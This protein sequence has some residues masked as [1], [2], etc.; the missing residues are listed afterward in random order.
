MDRHTLIIN[1]RHEMPRNK[2]LFW[3]GITILLWIG[4]ISLWYPVFE[5]FYRMATTEVPAA[6]IAKWIN[7]NI[8]RVTFIHGLEMLVVTPVVLFILSWLKRHQ[9]PS[10]H[11][12][13]TNVDYAAHFKIAV[14]QLEACGNS[15]LVTVFHDAQGQITAVNNQID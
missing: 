4:F 15:Q 7:G 8:H 10:E 5:I 6:E 13:Y 2:V 1:K 3:D 9:G 12:V 14:T 11:I